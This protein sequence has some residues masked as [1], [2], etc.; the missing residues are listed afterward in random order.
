MTWTSTICVVLMATYGRTL[1]WKKRNTVPN[2]G[3]CLLSGKKNKYRRRAC[4][5]GRLQTM[6]VTDVEGL[7]VESWR[8]WDYFDHQA[9]VLELWLFSTGSS[10][11]RV[12]V[13]HRSH[14]VLRYCLTLLLK[15][16]FLLSYSS[17]R[18]PIILLFAFWSGVGLTLIAL[19]RD[20][21]YFPE[22]LPS[23]LHEVV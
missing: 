13:R 20:R 8:L 11:V 7:G 22:I 12:Q 10:L 3:G 18:F 2:T 14:S 16:Y 4:C 23:A 6:N 17:C 19:Y 15:L 21:S 1:C 5:R 9:R